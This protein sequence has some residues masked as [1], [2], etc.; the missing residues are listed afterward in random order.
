M[1]VCLVTPHNTWGENCETR[2]A[3]VYVLVMLPRSKVRT[4]YYFN[5]F[6]IKWSARKGIFP[7]IDVTEL[8][9]CW[10]VGSTAHDT[11]CGI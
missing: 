6:E 3:D 7:Q 10:L 2:I 1:R 11:S 9:K 4:G 8:V 5:G